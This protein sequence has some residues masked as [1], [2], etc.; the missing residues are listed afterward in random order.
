MWN[1]KC[2]LTTNSPKFYNFGKHFY[3]ISGVF[4][5][6]LEEIRFYDTVGTSEIGLFLLIVYFILERVFVV[7][8][9]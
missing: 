6:H 3:R 7:Y 9:P 2:Y 1:A 5:S 8:A 4:D